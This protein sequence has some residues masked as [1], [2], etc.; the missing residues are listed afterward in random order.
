MGRICFTAELDEAEGPLLL[1]REHR[2]SRDSFLKFVAA[3][4]ELRTELTAEGEMIVMPPAHSR[5]G[6]QNFEI[7]LQLGTW[8]RRD[9]HG[10]AYDSSTGFDLPDGSN[11]SPDASWVMVSRLAM[12]SPDER[13]TY[14]PLCPDFV[15]ELRSKSDSVRMLRNKM[16]EYIA[17]GAKLGWLIDPIERTVHVYRPLRPVEILEDPAEVSA[18]PELPGF[19]LDLDPIFNPRF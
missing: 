19:V 11:R 16:I 8:A 13:D 2:V 6:N 3:N 12:L 10:Q 9:G 18:D 14:L 17:N 5:T 1:S 7:L 15:A 4:P